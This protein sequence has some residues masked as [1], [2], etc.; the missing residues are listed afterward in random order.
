MKNLSKI[1]QFFFPFIKLFLFGWLMMCNLGMIIL[2]M[3]KYDILNSGTFM[4]WVIFLSAIIFLTFGCFAIIEL[5][6]ERTPYKDIINKKYPNLVKNWGLGVE[7]LSWNQVIELMRKA[8]E[9]V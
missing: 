3:I 2:V 5:F 1:I 8:R 6:R 9:E 4:Q 7:L